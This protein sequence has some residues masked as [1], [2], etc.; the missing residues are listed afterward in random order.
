[1]ETDT[2]FREIQ[3]FRQWWLWTL[4]GGVALLMLVLGPISWGGLIVIGAIAAFLYNLRLQTEVRAD[5]IYFKMWPL[6]WSFRRIAWSEIER[7]E[8][9]QYRPLREFGGWGIRW[10][11]GKLA[12]NV[13]GNRGVWIDR[14]NGRAVLIGSQRPEDFVRAIEE[15]SES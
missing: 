8:P 14:A 5:G 7:Y 10:A 3:R 9:R 6:H 15:V 4:L 11:P 2:A 12:Y 13:S 1:M